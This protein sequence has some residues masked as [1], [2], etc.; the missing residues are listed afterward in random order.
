LTTAINAALLDAV[1]VGI[2]KRL[3]AGPI[4]DAKGLT[5]PYK[6]LLADTAFQSAIGRAT[7][8]EENV[9]KRLSLATERF[10]TVV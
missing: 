7:A 8:D 6:A 1:M 10:S 3:Q 5:A 4:E 2:T 9:R